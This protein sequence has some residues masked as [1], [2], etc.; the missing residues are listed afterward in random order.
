VGHKVQKA[1]NGLD[2]PAGRKVR[3]LRVH[4]HTSAIRPGEKRAKRL[5]DVTNAF[6]PQLPKKRKI[7][8][9]TLIKYIMAAAAAEFTKTYEGVDVQI[10]VLVFLTLAIAESEVA[11][12]VLSINIIFHVRNLTTDELVCKNL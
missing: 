12:V 10:H 2:P 7:N 9:I 5:T 6:N 11:V 8:A 1:E 3:K 4:E